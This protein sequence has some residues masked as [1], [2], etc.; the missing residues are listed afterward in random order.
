[1]KGIAEKI[2]I[3]LWP[4]REIARLEQRAEAAYAAMYDAPRYGVRDCYDDAQA[5]LSQALAI[6]ERRSMK[7]A[8]ERLQHRKDH[9]YKVYDHQFR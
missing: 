8:V 7:D 5:Y 2:R 3:R 1:M 4:S 6:A 9:I